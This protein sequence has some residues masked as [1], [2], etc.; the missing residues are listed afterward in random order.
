MIP[1]HTSPNTSIEEINRIFLAQKANIQA[2]KRTNASQRIAKLNKLKKLMFDRREDLQKAIYEDFRKPAPEFDLTEIYPVVA[3]IRYA[4][5]HLHDWMR[6]EEVATPIQMMGSRSWIIKEP[7]GQCLLMSPWNYPVQLAL[8]PLV[9][10]IAAGNVCMMKPSEFTPHCSAALKKILAEVFNENEVAVIEG[11]HTVASILL[12]MKFDH[13]HFTGS[14]AVGKIVMKAASENLTSITLELGGKS[15]VFVDETASAD[16]AGKRLTWGKFLNEGQTCIA[17]DYVLVHKSKSEELVAALKKSIEK[18]FGADP[19]QS[20]D[21]CRMVNAKH[22]QR[23]KSMVDEAL[24]K[25][26]KILIGGEFDENENYISPTVIGNVSPDS[27]LMQEEIF[28]PVLPLMNYDDIETALKL[29]NEKEK[30]LALYIFSKKEKNIEHILQHTTAGGTCINDN[31]IHIAQPNLPFGGVNNSGMGKSMGKYGFH[32]FTN[33]RA[34]LKQITPVSSMEFM[35]PP[36]TGFV[37]KMIDF[38][39]KYF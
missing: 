17:P 21:L 5:T 16:E 25:G 20:K 23:V 26:A 27:R 7:K 36:Y 28:G 35:Y 22:Y 37:K 38:T 10:A 4:V 32:E 29:V 30:P 24:E 34:V 15:A 12:S 19:K 1:V 13:I 8:A 6:D 33:E 11:D 3:E 18:S 39:L 2:V 9:S 31:V 14:P